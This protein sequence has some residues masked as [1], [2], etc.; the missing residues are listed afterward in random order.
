[1]ILFNIDQLKIFLVVVILFE[2]FV[3]PS[4]IPFFCNCEW[5][6]IGRKY[7]I[8]ADIAIAFM[9]H[10][11]LYWCWWKMREEELEIDSFI[12]IRR[13]ARRRRCGWCCNDMGCVSSTIFALLWRTFLAQLFSLSES[14]DVL[15]SKCFVDAFAIGGFS[16][17]IFLRTKTMM[18][19]DSIAK[20]GP[21]LQ[22]EVVWGIR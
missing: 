3:Y 20:I 10:S 19:C 17:Y 4:V 18:K 1:M 7:V 14:C 2:L 12:S 5:I 15:L 6:K 11:M 9:H 22:D 16:D 8:S 21:T 13:V